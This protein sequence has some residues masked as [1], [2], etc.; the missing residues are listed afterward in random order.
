MRFLYSI[1]LTLLFACFL[2][3]CQVE[4][5]TDFIEIN[6]LSVKGKKQAIDYIETSKVQN[7]IFSILLDEL[8]QSDLK[9][10]ISF[11]ENVKIAGFLPKD[12]SSFNLYFKS[13]DEF[14]DE[15]AI[16][17]E[18]FHAFQA[19]F[20]GYDRMLPN[21]DGVIKGAVNLEYEAK[22]MKALSAFYHD[23][24]FFETPS[25]RGL[26][27]FTMSLFDKSGKVKTFQ[28]DSGQ[29][30]Q[31]IGL[32]THFQQHWQK[33]NKLENVK[34]VYAHPV[35]SALGPDACFSLFKKLK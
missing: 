14:R 22:L 33:R 13:L 24:A 11:S 5:K 25:Q 29:H 17:E 28:L 1:V 32:V 23:Q 20:Y 7:K 34:S 21:K 19:K 35:D 30:E 4:Q 6:G 2:L 15:N 10:T 26:L 8:D 16:L 3:G 31:Y 12:G 18:F 27:D 9:L